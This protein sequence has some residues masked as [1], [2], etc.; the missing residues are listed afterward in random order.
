MCEGSLGAWIWRLGGEGGRGGGGRGG[1]GSRDGRGEEVREGGAACMVCM[2]YCALQY[3]PI[4]TPFPLKGLCM[5]TLV[6]HVD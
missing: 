4:Y 5:E 3:R 1:D 6:F 2:L